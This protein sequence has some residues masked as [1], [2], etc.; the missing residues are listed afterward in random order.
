MQQAAK[1]CCEGS[2]KQLSIEALST[3]KI[4]F[5][6]LQAGEHSPPGHRRLAEGFLDKAGMRDAGERCT[7]RSHKAQAGPEGGVGSHPDPPEQNDNWGLTF[8]T[9]LG[10][11]GVLCHL[12]EGESLGGVFPGHQETLLS[13]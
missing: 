1:T 8:R 2:L 11:A 12:W 10:L 4:G 6:Y 9:L 13:T 5:S 3:G 7:F